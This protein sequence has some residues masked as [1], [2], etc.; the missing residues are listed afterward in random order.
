MID[1]KKYEAMAKLE[2]SET[3]RQL[4]S[5]RA[6]SLVNSFSALES[7]DTSGAEPL[8]TVLDIQNIL[9]E[10][11][12]KKWTS[13][14]ELLSGAPDQHGGYFRIPKALD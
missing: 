4:L 3:E 6:D 13:R 2:L 9:R 7:I 14:E 1:I 12:V 5:G 11:L 10:D 8:V